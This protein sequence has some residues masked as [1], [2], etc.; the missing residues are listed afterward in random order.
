MIKTQLTSRQYEIDD[1]LRAYTLRKLGRLDRYLPRSAKA[2]AM[3]VEIFRDP[4]SNADERYKVKAYLEVPGPD[5]VADTATLNPY[6][7][8]DIVE[9]KLKIQIR[10]YKEKHGVK[11]FRIKE[12]F[13]RSENQPEEAD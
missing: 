2:K 7:G 8:I 4:A 5:I 9:E 1:D 6:A 10:K 12:F 13:G 11:R 3:Q